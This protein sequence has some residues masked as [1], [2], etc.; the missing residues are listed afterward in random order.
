[1]LVLPHVGGWLSSHLQ[2]VLD[3]LQR[4][5]SAH[6]CHK[7]QQRHSYGSCSPLAESPSCV[8]VSPSVHL[9]EG[10][11]LIFQPRHLFLDPATSQLIGQEVRHRGHKRVLAC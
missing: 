10:M 3:W 9:G 5:L 1:M 4:L 8:S 6:G 11:V 7:I 2:C